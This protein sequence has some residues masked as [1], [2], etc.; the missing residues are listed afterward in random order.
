MEQLSFCDSC[1]E[2]K[3]ITDDVLGGKVAGSKLTRVSPDKVHLFK[4]SW[5]W[6]AYPPYQVTHPNILPR[7]NLKK[8]PLSKKFRRRMRRLV[9][10]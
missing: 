5:F 6:W 3:K 7:L 8:N 1:T 2:I 4:E 10:R 9:N